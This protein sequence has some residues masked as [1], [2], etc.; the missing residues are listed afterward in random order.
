MLLAL[1]EV[2]GDVKET[3]LEKLARKY[4]FQ[5]PAKLA[6]DEEAEIA[7]RIVECYDVERKRRG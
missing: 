4:I 3:Y 7:R 5:Q 1:A 6:A 2:I